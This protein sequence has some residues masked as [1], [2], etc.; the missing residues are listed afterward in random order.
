MTTSLDDLDGDELL[1]AYHQTRDE[2]LLEAYLER[3]KC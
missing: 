1:A 3:E 2:A